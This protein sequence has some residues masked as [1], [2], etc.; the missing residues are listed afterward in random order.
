[1][2][3]KFFFKKISI[4]NINQSIDS[5]NKSV[6]SFGASMED[7]TKEMSEDIGKSNRD[8]EARER[9]NRENLEKIWG[10]RK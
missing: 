10:K 3:W 5:F 2:T 6:Q 4:K 7:I 8:H 1:M 9:K